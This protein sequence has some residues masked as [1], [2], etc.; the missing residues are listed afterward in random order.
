MS[1]RAP[2]T[3]LTVNAMSLS[4][5]LPRQLSSRNRLSVQ[6]RT[7]GTLAY[8]NG[9]WYGR[10]PLLGPADL[11]VRIAGTLDGPEPAA[12][13]TLCLLDAQRSQLLA[14]MHPHLWAD[15]LERCAGTKIEAAS[16]RNAIERHY[17]IEAACAGAFGDHELVELAIHADWNAALLGLYLRR[18]KV[19]ETT[20][21]LRPWRWPA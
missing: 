5:V 13:R 7:L 6:D 20:P 19:V 18:G 9:W 3:A 1:A 17:R 16:P 10:A 21:N 15:W 2:R 12:R 14:R 8:V 11:R 4:G